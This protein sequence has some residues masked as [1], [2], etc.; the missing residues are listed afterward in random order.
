MKK[1]FSK[2]WRASKQPRKQRKYVYNL[3][4]HLKK[5]IMSSTLSKELRVKFKKRN[6]TIKKGDKVKI[7]RGNFKGKTGEIITVDRKNSKIYVS[8][9]DQIKRDGSKSQYPIHP[10]NVMITELKLD[11]KNRIKSLERK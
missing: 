5:K 10:S 11:D 9:V 4:H 2:S 1:T 6:T 8:G 3:P 7:L